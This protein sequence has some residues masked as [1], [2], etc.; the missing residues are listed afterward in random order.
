MQI[1]LLKG[2]GVVSW[3]VLVLDITDNNLS[4]SLRCIMT[5]IPFA[6]TC[7]VILKLTYWKIIAL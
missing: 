3:L 6:L 2:L 4:C 7:N 5:V 1:G